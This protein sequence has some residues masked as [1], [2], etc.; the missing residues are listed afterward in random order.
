MRSDTGDD[1]VIQWSVDE[2]GS[3]LTACEVSIRESDGVSFTVESTY[4]LQTSSSVISSNTCA[5]PVSVLV[6]EPYNLVYGSHIY[7]K[8]TAT[9]AYG[10]SDESEQGNGAR[11][12]SVPST[13][14]VSNYVP[15]TSATKVTI[16]WTEPV[17][18]GG[19]EVDDYQIYYALPAEEFA[20]LASGV[21][22]REYIAYPLTTGL[23]Y[24]FKVRA[25]NIQGFGDFSDAVTILT[26]QIPDTP[27][28]PSTVF[29]P[30]TVTV[31]WTQPDD[32][33]SPITGYDVYIMR[34]DGRYSFELTD[35]NGFDATVMINT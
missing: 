29:A 13:V 33:G 16:Q 24:R 25:R 4:C 19:A 26:A 5:I 21:T 6:A 15:G 11:I 18:K 31:T 32:R 30:D 20:V 9:N 27:D 8:V 7:A 14:V 12:Y 3:P 17:D 35:C 34:S 22:S 23:E 10:T 1:V 2:R 28:V